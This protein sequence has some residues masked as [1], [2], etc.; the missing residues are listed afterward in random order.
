[1]IGFPKCTDTALLP[2]AMAF[3][4]RQLLVLD[5]YQLAGLVFRCVVT[6]AAPVA[7]QGFLVK[8]VWEDDR[9]SSELTEDLPMVQAIVGLISREGISS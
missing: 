5:V 7:V 9:S 1:M 3:R 4:A 6:E 2:S 8:P